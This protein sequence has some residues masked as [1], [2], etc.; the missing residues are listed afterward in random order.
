MMEFL[1]EHRKYERC[2]KKNARQNAKNTMV[3]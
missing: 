3:K 2:N 1:D